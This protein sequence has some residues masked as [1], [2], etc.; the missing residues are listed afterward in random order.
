MRLIIMSTTQRTKFTWTTEYDQAFTKPKVCLTK[1]PVLYRLLWC[2]KAHKGIGFAINSTRTMAPYKQD[3]TVSQ[4]L[5]QDIQFY[6]VEIAGNHIGYMEVQ[7]VPHGNAMFWGDN[8]SY[9]LYINPKDWMR[10]KIKVIVIVAS[11][12]NGIS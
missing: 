8:T 3:H 10:L 5:S 7:N 11:K 9:S 12:Y 6:W 2:N 1:T 4:V